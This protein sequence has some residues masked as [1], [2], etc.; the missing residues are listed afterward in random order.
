MDEYDGYY[1]AEQ[2]DDDNILK[3]Y[4]IFLTPG[5]YYL[6]VMHRKEEYA[7]EDIVYFFYTVRTYD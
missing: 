6:T 5:T 3:I 4:D 7:G 1:F 2:E